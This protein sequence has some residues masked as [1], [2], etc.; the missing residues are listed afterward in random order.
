MEKSGRK[1]EA[2]NADATRQ[3]VAGNRC[4]F[5]DRKIAARHMF[6]ALQ[7]SERYGVFCLFAACQPLCN[8]V[9]FAVGIRSID[10]EPLKR[11]GVCVIGVFK[12]A[13]AH[14][15]FATAAMSTLRQLAVG[16][17]IALA[18]SKEGGGISSVRRSSRFLSYAEFERVNA[19]V[20][21]GKGARAPL[22]VGVA[23]DKMISA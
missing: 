18:A 2:R 1:R 21:V 15:F 13:E 19:A 3:A 22:I 14:V 6:A 4:R 10:G 7:A 5:G 23:V 8:L 9:D 16:G 17:E 12:R 11:G 20:S